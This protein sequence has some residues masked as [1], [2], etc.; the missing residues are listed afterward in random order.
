MSGSLAFVLQGV[1]QPTKVENPHESIDEAFSPFYLLGGLEFAGED[2]YVR[3][4]VGLAF[5]SWSG[6]DAPEETE[7]APVLGLALGMERPLGGPFH[8]SPELELRLAPFEAF[9]LALQLPVG[10]RAAGQQ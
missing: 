5:L 8:I 10:W 2:V 6:A 4:S 1:W 7:R 3:F 9:V